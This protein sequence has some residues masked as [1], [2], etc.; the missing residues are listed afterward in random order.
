MEIRSLSV[1]DYEE[2]IGLWSRAG[3]PFKPK[4]RDSRESISREIKSHPD[5]FLGAFEDGRLVGTAI[6]SCDLRKGWINRLAVDPAY[7]RRGVAKTLISEGERI[8]RRDGVR[9]FCSLIEASNGVSRRLFEDCGYVL[10]RDI[11]YFCKR[12]SGEV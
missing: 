7:R 6:M 11:L 1:A 9:I 5:Y 10:H 8:L 2:M 3:L 12:D 4:G